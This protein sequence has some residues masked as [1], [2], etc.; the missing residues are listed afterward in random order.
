MT[1]AARMEANQHVLY[2]MRDPQGPPRTTR[3]PQNVVIGFLKVGY[4]KLFLLVSI[5]LG[6]GGGGSKGV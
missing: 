5:D 3:D 1:S 2:I 4:K 6:S